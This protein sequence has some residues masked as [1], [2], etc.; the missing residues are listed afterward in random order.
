M[1]LVDG[2]IGCEIRKTYAKFGR[3]NFKVI[4]T[5]QWWKIPTGSEKE[6]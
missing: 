5:K 4:A 3:L 6:S 2:R 1:F